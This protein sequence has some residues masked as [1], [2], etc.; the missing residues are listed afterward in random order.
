MPQKALASV[1]RPWTL[2]SQDSRSVIGEWWVCPRQLV[3]AGSWDMRSAEQTAIWVPVTLIPLT[4]KRSMARK[5]MVES[6]AMLA[7]RQEARHENT[8]LREPGP[9]WGRYKWEGG[10]QNYQGVTKKGRG[11][12]SCFL[13][14]A[15]QATGRGGTC[16]FLFLSFLFLFLAYTEHF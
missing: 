10:Q 4:C 7:S 6:P 12:T 11:L 9:V 1:S 2:S 5:L 14:Q 16:I 13:G 8:K 3:W 15:L